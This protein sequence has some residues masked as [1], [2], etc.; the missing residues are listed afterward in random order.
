MAD[1]PLHF[2]CRSIVFF[3]DHGIEFFGD[4]VD[5][6]R[7]SD[8]HFHPFPQIRIAFD[9]RRDAYVDEDVA[10]FF[11]HGVLFQIFGKSAV[12]RFLRRQG[13]FPHALHEHL[14]R[15][16]LRHKIRRAAFKRLCNDLFARKRAYDDGFAVQPRFVHL[17]QN[18]KAVPA[19]EQQFGNH[20]VG[21]RFQDQFYTVR[22]VRRRAGHF[23]IRSAVDR[24]RQFRVL[25]VAVL[26]D[27]NFLLCHIAS[28]SPFFSADFVRSP[29]F[30]CPYDHTDETDIIYFTIFR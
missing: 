12:F 8:R 15:K 13:D 29:V 26:N 24:R 21:I 14:R 22:A 23:K 25:P 10:D 30:R 3:P 4:A 11:V 18:V 7:I 2:A 20:D 16:G 6:V 28:K 5:D 9:V 27:N 17:V 19:A 1:R